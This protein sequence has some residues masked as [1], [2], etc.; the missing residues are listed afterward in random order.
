LHHNLISCFDYEEKN[1]FK[2][3]PAP[4]MKKNLYYISSNFAS[5]NKHT[6]DVIKTISILILWFTTF[7]Q[8]FNTQFS[9]LFP[10][11]FVSFELVCQYCYVMHMKIDKRRK[12]CK[13]EK[14][15]FRFQSTMEKSIESTMLKIK[16][17]KN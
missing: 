10:S 11:L 15:G 16:T 2:L 4:Q 8:N 6:H 3:N 17:A 13:K 12:T 5:T 9:S 1:C 7:F 14:E